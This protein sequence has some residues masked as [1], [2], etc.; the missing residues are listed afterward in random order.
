MNDHTQIKQRLIGA[1][2]LAALGIIF[3][4][5]ILDNNTADDFLVNGSSIPPKPE[6]IIGLNKAEMKPVIQPVEEVTAQRISVDEE[7]EK[8]MVDPVK[9][10]DNKT[11]STKS[12]LD[13]NQNIEKVAI[14][15]T[16]GMSVPAITSRAWAV[17]VGSFGDSSN[18]I[19]LRDKLRK[20]SYSAFVDKL[21]VKKTIVYRVR[22]GPFIK[23]DMAEA[24]S[25]ELGNKH[26]IKGMV[27]AHP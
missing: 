9:T 24:V 22:I 2:V 14:D 11:T 19:R 6:H 1:I 8:V 25:L 12:T 3:I 10:Q 21:A 17:Q 4:P 5:M 23:R 20:S 7:I 27:V 26:K 15:T 13:E 18:A 16:N